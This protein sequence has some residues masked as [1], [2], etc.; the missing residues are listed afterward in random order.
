MATSSVNIVNTLGAGS[1]VDTKSLAQSLVDAERTPRKDAIDAKIKKEEAKITGHGAIKSLLT[2]LQTALAKINDSKEFTSIT[3]NNTQPTAFGAT[4][5]A[6]ALSGSYSIEVSQIAKAT[7]L[8]TTNFAETDTPINSGSE[9][10][11]SLTVGGGSPQT[12]QVTT[13]TPAGVVSAINASTTGVSAQL[14]NTGSGYS[15]VFS[16]QTGAA[17]AFTISNLPSDMTMRAQAL[18]TAQDASITINGLPITSTTNQLSDTI[19]GL[20]LDLYAPTTGAARLDLNRQTAGIKDNLRAVVD[21]YNQ[22]ED[23]LKVLGDRASK[24]EEFGGA[25]AGDSILGTVRN[26]IRALFT[27]EAEEGKIYLGGDKTKPLNPDVAAAWQVGIGFDRNG[28]M[29][30]NE[31][32]LDQAMTSYPDQVVAYFTANTD[33]QSIYSPAPGGMAGDAVKDIDAVLRSTGLLAKQSELA[34]DR[35][36]RY[37]EDLAKLEARMSQLLERYTKQFSVMESIVG[38]S[39]STR[40]SLKSSFEGLMAMYTN[41]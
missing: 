7:R 20:T 6:S 37:Q 25:L 16:G 27:K 30:L 21:A 23:G 40:T 1:G 8:A 29:T 5:S 34:D 9:F 13:A 28:K 3:A 22:F 35:I 10:E 31:G 26:Q 36:E 19:P 15:I 12:I 38:Q 11:L 39:T 14:L 18:D 41:K 24:V 2:Q 32:K 33:A 17:N 4:S